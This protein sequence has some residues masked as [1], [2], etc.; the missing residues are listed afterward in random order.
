MG[1][2]KTLTSSVTSLKKELSG[3]Y[4]VLKKI[5]GLGP[6]AFGDVNAVL[7][8]SGQF[9]NGV[10]T[11]VFAKSSVTNAPK[12]SNST[13]MGAAKPSSNAQLSNYEKTASAIQ[14]QYL[15]MGIR[16]AKFSIAAGVAQTVTGVVSAGMGMLPNV[17]DVAQRAGSFYGSSAMFGGTNRT[18]NQLNTMAAM[19]GGITGPTGTA[20]AFG[21]LTSFSYMPGSSNMAR[22]LGDVGAAAKALNMDNASA[23]QAVGATSTGSF[24][25]QLYQYG[26]RQ[27]DDKGNL[28]KSG[29]IS[30]D[31]L[32]RIFYPGK[33]VSKIGAEQFAKDSMGMNLDYQLGT[34]GI[35]GAQL[36][37]MKAEMGLA[38]TGKNPNLD[39]VNTSGNPLNPFLQ[40][41]GSEE[42]LTQ[43][44]EKD[45]LAGAQKAAD[46]LVILNNAL[47]K[48]PSL[49]VQM[50]SAL[51]T[52]NGTKSGNGVMNIVK[53][54]AQ[55]GA[56]LYAGS[57][58]IKYL[59]GLKGGAAAETTALE[60]AATT[61]ANTGKIVI[62]PVTGAASH[63]ATAV[64][65]TAATA[66]KAS[67]LAMASRV[68]GKV[69]IPLTVATSSYDVYK[70]SHD[71]E[72]KAYAAKWDKDHKKASFWDRFK[73]SINMIGDY[74]GGQKYGTTNSQN[75]GGPTSGFFSN[76]G[77]NTPSVNS[78]SFSSGS[79][80]M[81]SGPLASSM[82]ATSISKTMGA[83][84]GAKDPSM[85]MAGALNY[86]TGEDTPMPTGTP[87]YARFAGKVVERNLSRDLGIAVEVDHG[88]GYSSIY[89]H[90]NLKVV[91]SG[92]E[93]KIGDLIGKS[94][95]TGRVTG[96]HLHFELRKGKVPT[97]PKTYNPDNKGDGKKGTGSSAA[98][99]S[100][101]AANVS[102]GIKASGKQL[103]A[104][105]MSQGFS[106][107]GA[108]GILGNLIQ[109]S[110]LSTGSI[111]DGGTSFG[112][113]QW[114]KGRG[115]N[116]KK[117]AVSMGK[118][119]T[120][121]EVQKAFLLKEM[122]TYPD[123]V[124]KLQDPNIGIVDAAA[125]F[126]R[127]FERPKD[128]SDKAAGKRASLGIGAVQGGPNDGFN[129]NVN[130]ATSGTGM[131]STRNTNATSS[132]SGT[133]NIYVTLQI[134]QA[135]QQ[136]AE[137]FAKTLKK[138]LEK[139]NQLYKL[140]SN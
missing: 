32:Q 68:A 54:V 5:K 113:A 111:G 138:Y 50:N 11:P 58:L 90:L 83:G 128:Q 108:T 39:T 124:K 105:L 132:N 131:L 55:G 4:D 72:M 70:L 19:R 78:F 126:M 7:Q 57:K 74:Y 81:A 130:D 12:F 129:I 84:F 92:Q 77:G 23:A 1:N 85:T 10:G 121:L 13:T 106:S 69:A 86:H 64:T 25:A 109:E 104:W 94:G 89:G 45:I 44:T 80:P 61:A 31:I 116:L 49:I 16:E 41:Q 37:K 110:G 137:A 107:N 122:K 71:E 99:A 22:G 53:S 97:D 139:D 91:R 112:I 34:M 76:V 14:T 125:L 38:V 40:I 26:I 88:D 100:V 51:Q 47:E 9:G 75:R 134:Q 18:Q 62:D 59:K 67:K 20:E 98:G 79:Q 43:K 29:D 136:E 21:T 65:E 63:S 17:G 119:Y 33:D 15:D 96:P 127:K 28:R 115:D 120:D 36:T 93:I 101:N 46:A 133:N 114:H 103:H 82:S 117:F 24:G 30:K 87:V 60:T 118:D 102:K 52:F 73:E 27:Y 3:V 95:S 6:S 2:V 48:T 66:A 56:Q 8:K 123:M 140:G 135:N 35:Q 42:K